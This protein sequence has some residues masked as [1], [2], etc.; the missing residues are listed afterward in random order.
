MDDCFCLS[1]QQL[2]DHAS[3]GQILHEG[4]QS[5]DLESHLVEVLFQGCLVFARL[6]ALQIELLLL[7]CLA[8][9]KTREDAKDLVKQCS[10]LLFKLSL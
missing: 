4:D 1:R 6:D 2:L 7:A 5:R 3:K 9:I 8:F 10:F